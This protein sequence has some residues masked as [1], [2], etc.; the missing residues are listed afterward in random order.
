MNI[1]STFRYPIFG[2]GHYTILGLEHFKL[3]VLPEGEGRAVASS[4]LFSSSSS[5]LGE[6]S[7]DWI[8]HALPVVFFRELLLGIKCFNIFQEGMVQSITLGNSICKV[9]LAIEF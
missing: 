3:D 4:R 1:L 7:M 5:K 6:V 9:K 2:G 8:I